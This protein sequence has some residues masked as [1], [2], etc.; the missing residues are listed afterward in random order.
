MIQKCLLITIG[1]IFN[2]NMCDFVHGGR[3]SH[4]PFSGL[5]PSRNHLVTHH[6]Y[7]CIT[8]IPK[9]LYFHPYNWTTL[10]IPFPYILLYQSYIKTYI[11][12]HINLFPQHQQ[13]VHSSMHNGETQVIWPEYTTMR[14]MT[15]V[16]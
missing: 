11:L 10:V 12:C 13:M 3:V 16:G 5:F 9:C 14:I 1:E 7:I 8:F 6:T 2:I 15:L 4:F